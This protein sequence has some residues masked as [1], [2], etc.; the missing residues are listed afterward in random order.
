KG[1]MLIYQYFDFSTAEDGLTEMLYPSPLPHKGRGNYQWASPPLMAYGP[2]PTAHREDFMKPVYSVSRRLT[3]QN[4][5]HPALF[6]YM[7]S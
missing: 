2:G 6:F 7:V 3:S 5:L 4:V 1:N